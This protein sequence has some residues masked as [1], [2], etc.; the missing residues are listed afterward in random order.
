MQTFSTIASNASEA[1][2]PHLWR[3]LRLCWSASLGQTGD[4]LQTA[5]GT[6][7]GTF[8]GATAADM[9]Q[10][11]LGYLCLD[12]DGGDDKSLISGDERY[13][14]GNR[15]T[16]SIWWR[17]DQASLTVNDPIISSGGYYQNGDGAFVVRPS[18]TTNIQFAS[19]GSGG[20]NLE[21]L[22]TCPVPAVGQRW[23]QTILYCDGS[24]LRVQHDGKQLS[25]TVSHAKEINDLQQGLRFS[26]DHN[27]DRVDGS[28]GET[29]FWARDLTQPERMQLWRSGPGEWLGRKRRR[30]YS[31]A[32]APVVYGQRIPRHRSILGGGLR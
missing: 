5:V 22:S 29:A 9:W 17:T 4:T 19:Y 7:T 18:S 27:D 1:A 30:V 6:T 14:L 11:R 20:T 28:I 25:S 24:T 32:A 8:S 23:H 15:W 13:R 26:D 16:M 10:R 21:Y 31:I 12:F 3:G 2:Y